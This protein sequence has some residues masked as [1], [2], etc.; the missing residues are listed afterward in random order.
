MQFLA[1]F[2]PFFN[3]MA[4]QLTFLEQSVAFDRSSAPK[5]C[6]VSGW[7]QGNDAN[8]AIDAE[9]MFLL[10]EFTYDLEKSNA[11][12]FDVVES[13]GSSLVD[14]IRLDFSSNHGSL[15]HTCIYRVRVHGHEPYSVS[16]MA[17]QSWGMGCS[18]AAS[19]YWVPSLYYPCNCYI[20]CSYS[21]FRTIALTL[22][23][24]WLVGTAVVSYF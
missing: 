10:A 22:R 12:T 7:F 6:R 20:P 13:T 8:S 1:F 24:F 17:T 11:Q 2:H 9:K 18:Q 3:N 21:L 4:T 16:M 23:I 15:S 19:L 14:M 5:D